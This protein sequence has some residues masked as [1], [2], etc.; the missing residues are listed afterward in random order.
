[1]GE[2]QQPR[3]PRPD[4]PRYAPETPFPRYRFVPGLNPHPT[5]HPE[6][7]SY[8]RDEDEPVWCAPQ[9]WSQSQAYRYGVD[10]YNHAFWWEAHEAWEG[11]WH[12]TNKKEPQ[13]EFIQGLIQVAAAIFKRHQGRD[14][15]SVRLAQIGLG[16]LSKVLASGEA[17]GGHYMGL[18]LQTFLS[19]ATDYFSRNDAPDEGTWPLIQLGDTRVEAADQSR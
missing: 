9:D 6:G 18:D 5:H 14:S 15:G 2:I 16:R 13:G 7:H 3:A 10:L 1:M 12:T 11:F 8:D 4:W 19:D 17:P